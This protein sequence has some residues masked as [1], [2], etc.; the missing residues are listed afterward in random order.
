MRR[1]TKVSIRRKMS[2]TLACL[3]AAISVLSTSSAVP[4]MASD[5][6]VKMS[7]KKEKLEKE[8]LH[9]LRRIY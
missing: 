2:G 9:C 8:R 1:K 3:L 5:D 4:T 6:S 7:Y